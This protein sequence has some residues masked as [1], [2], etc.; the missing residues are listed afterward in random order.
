MPSPRINEDEL[1]W[2]KAMNL[3]RVEASGVRTAAAA[4]VPLVAGQLLGHPAQGLLVGLGGLYLS[5]TDKEGSTPV[6]M[7]AATVLNGVAV[8]AGSLAGTRVW[9][10]VGAMAVWAFLGGMAS[11]YGEVVLQIGFISTVTFA[12]ALGLA[13]GFAAGAAEAALFVAGGL[14]GT[15]LTLALWHFHEQTSALREARGADGTLSTGDGAGRGLL[16][17][18]GE[19]LTFRSIV[20]R[21]A[22]RLAL[23]ATVAV[24]IYK[25]LRLERGYWLIITVLVIVK[26]VFA[27]TRK[28][29]AERAAGSVV[30]GALAALLA[31]GIRN[32]VLLDLLLAAFSVLAYSQ[33]RHNYGVYAL[34]LTPFVVLMIETVEPTDWQIVFFRIG[35]T[36]F[37][38]CIALAISY[39]LRPKAAFGR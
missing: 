26:P 37:G 3:L 14:W 27:D 23:A 11:A 4:T 5:I 7:L 8:L 9:L 18:F 21:H 2:P 6:S 33:V 1:R 15:A 20:F 29:A 30:G 24:V 34:F 16:A 39:F 31:S 25:A 12:V 17:T 28:R 13:A 36:L 38:A 32:V 35:Y 22:L 19:N 10:A